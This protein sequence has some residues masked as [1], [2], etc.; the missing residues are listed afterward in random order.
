MSIQN[1]EVFWGNNPGI[2]F[3][4]KLLTQFFPR[5]FMNNDQKLNAISRLL[6]YIS[7]ALSFYKG[8]SI[9]IL[10]GIVGLLS[11]W[12]WNYYGNQSIDGETEGMVSE[13]S[14]PLFKKKLP[15]TKYVPPTRCNPF[16]NPMP[17]GISSK[18]PRESKLKE[19]ESDYDKVQSEIE[20]KFNSG[21]FKPVSDVFGRES[22]QRQF[23]TLPNTSEANDQDT[24]AKWLYSSPATCK[25]G[26]GEA[27]IQHNPRN[28]QANLFANV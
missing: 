13:G 9:Y 10:L 21:L 4:K 1:K 16:M 12:I 7:L 6:I 19:P 14:S 8:N 23:Y 22:S 28:L 24:F 18:R 2:L 5:K 26:N 11:I 3:Q 15:N 25:E 17:M 27:C 20:D